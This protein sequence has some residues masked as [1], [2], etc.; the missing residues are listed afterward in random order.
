MATT[1]AIV[2]RVRLISAITAFKVELI[3]VTIESK[4]ASKA[5]S[6]NSVVG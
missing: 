3:K 2:F 5:H 4:P 1:T 6:A